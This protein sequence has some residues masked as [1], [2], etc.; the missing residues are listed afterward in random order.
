MKR[1]MRKS[2][3]VGGGSSF[4]LERYDRCS[5]GTNTSDQI[6]KLQHN[7]EALLAFFI[8]KFSCHNLT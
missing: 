5:A 8:E 3:L 2:T 7:S 4:L 6:H 1:H